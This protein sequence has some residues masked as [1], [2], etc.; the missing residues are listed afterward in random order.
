MFELSP[1]D[2]AA[3]ANGVLDAR[4]REGVAVEAEAR[5]LVAAEVGVEPPERLG[6]L[7]DDGDGVAVVLEALGERRA[8]AAAAHDHEVHSA[9]RYTVGGPP[10]ASPRPGRWCGGPGRA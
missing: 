5:D 10:P 9:A 8:D 1:S 4:L 3:N 2:T 7:V 6:V